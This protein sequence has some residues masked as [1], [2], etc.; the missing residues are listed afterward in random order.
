MQIAAQAC[1]V[2]VQ[3]SLLPTIAYLGLVSRSRQ[4]VIPPL[5]HKAKKVN[6]GENRKPMLVYWLIE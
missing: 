1:L 4:A 6:Q 5:V 3:P 2:S